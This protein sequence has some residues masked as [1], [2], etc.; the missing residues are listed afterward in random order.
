MCQH[1]LL[2]SSLCGFFVGSI[3]PLHLSAYHT[4]IG[5]GRPPPYNIACYKTSPAAQQPFLIPH[6]VSHYPPLSLS[7]LQ[8]SIISPLSLTVN[9][10]CLTS[11]MTYELSTVFCRS[12]VSEENHKPASMSVPPCVATFIHLFHISTYLTSRF[13]QERIPKPSSYYHG[14]SGHAS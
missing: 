11:C 2:P 1:P 9:N 14:S 3:A 5:V 4:H 13:M 7:S 6:F 12:F 8:K 10:V